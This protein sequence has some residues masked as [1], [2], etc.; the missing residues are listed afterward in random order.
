MLTDA[1][2]ICDTMG[3]TEVDLNFA[4]IPLSH[5]YGFSNLI[6]PLLVRGVPMAISGD[7]M[8]RAVLDDLARTRATVDRQSVV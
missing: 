7:R 4:V 8:P 3:I 5:S 6:T 1:E 2:Q